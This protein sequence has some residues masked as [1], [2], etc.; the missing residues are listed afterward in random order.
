MPPERRETRAT[1]PLPA[2]GRRHLVAV[3][4]EQNVLEEEGRAVTGTD[5]SEQHEQ[6]PRTTAAV[7]DESRSQRRLCRLAQGAD[8]RSPTPGLQRVPEVPLGLQCQP[9]LCVPTRQRVE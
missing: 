4:N 5:E 9:D 3:A 8:L 6:H 1:F 7:L 2:A